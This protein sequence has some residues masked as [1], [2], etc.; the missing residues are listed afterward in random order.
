M[1]FQVYGVRT[2]IYTLR[3]VPTRNLL[4]FLSLLIDLTAQRFADVPQVLMKRERGENKEMIS[5]PQNGV[6]AS[7]ETR[8]NEQHRVGEKPL[9]SCPLQPDRLLRRCGA[10]W[11][12]LLVRAHQPSRA[13]LPLP[14][15]PAS[16]IG[17]PNPKFQILSSSPNPSPI[18]DHEP[19]STA[20]LKLQAS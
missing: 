5:T 15:V 8:R 3:T 9:V 10:R 7:T 18:C 12:L 2:I 16:N 11:Q 19:T 4:W 14:W 20:I 13:R 17:A 1:I 6:D